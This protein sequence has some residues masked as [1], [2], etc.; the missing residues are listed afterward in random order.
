M[1][2]IDILNRLKRMDELIRRKAT[3]NPRE[4]AARL[5]ISESLLYLNI[6]LLKSMGGPIQYCKEKD[7]YEYEEPVVLEMGYRPKKE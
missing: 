6:E 1:K 3:G 2:A 4:F 7:S 5:G